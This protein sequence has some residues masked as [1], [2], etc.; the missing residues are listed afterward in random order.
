[1]RLIFHLLKPFKTIFFIFF[2]YLSSN[3]TYARPDNIAAQAK[4]TASSSL[5]D[6]YAVP[7]QN[8]F[9]LFLPNKFET[10]TFLVENIS[11]NS[12]KHNWK[13][14]FFLIIMK[15]V[16][17]DALAKNDFMSFVWVAVSYEPKLLVWNRSY[18]DYL[19]FL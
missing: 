7:I 10:L 15:I 13:L 2:F 11:N 12:Y 5:N 8:E 9:Q 17:R 6:I 19:E 1:M 14:A 3:S 4:V 16:H 18:G